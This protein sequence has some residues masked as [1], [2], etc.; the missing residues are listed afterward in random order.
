MVNHESST[1][2]A[3]AASLEAPRSD[4][5][6]PREET[7]AEHPDAVF[8]ALSHPRRRYLLSALTARDGEQPL[9][10][11]ATDVVAWEEDV[12][13]EN[14]SAEARRHCR[15]ALH[16]VHLPKL[17]ALGVVDYDPDGEPTVRAADTDGVSAVFERVDADLAD[18]GDSPGSDG[19]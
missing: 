12:P 5:D 1:D 17:A 2:D 19:A 10:R 8:A 18:P 6:L 14:V 7:T 16:H 4:V 13:R 3:V 15:I 11:L 9:A